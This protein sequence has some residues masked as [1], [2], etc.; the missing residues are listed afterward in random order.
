ME[1]QENMQ[2]PIYSLL[3]EIYGGLF[4]DIENELSSDLKDVIFQ[5]SFNQLTKQQQEQFGRFVEKFK[6][7]KI[8]MPLLLSYEKGLSEDSKR[9]IQI[10]ENEKEN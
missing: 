5:R 7:G 2:E 4:S 3:S 9:L 8:F 1:N 10:W 6:E